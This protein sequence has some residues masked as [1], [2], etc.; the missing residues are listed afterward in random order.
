MSMDTQDEIDKSEEKVSPRQSVGYVVMGA[1]VLLPALAYVQHGASLF[2]QDAFLKYLAIV[3][4]SSAV[5]GALFSK[6]KR[7]VA[8]CLCG[9]L[10][11]VG[12]AIALPLYVIL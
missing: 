10:A 11:G 9:V 7:T 2:G 6:P 1:G 8:G 4:L 3:V 12:G 5:G